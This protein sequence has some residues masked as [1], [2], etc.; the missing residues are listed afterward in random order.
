MLAAMSSS[1]TP[2]SAARRICARLSSPRR[3]LAPAQQHPE[4][5]TL[6]LGQRDTI[7]YVHRSLRVGGPDELTVE[8]N[9]W[10][11]PTRLHAQA[12]PVSGVHRRLCALTSAPAGRSRY[13]TV[14]RRHPAFGPPDD[15]HP[16]TRRSNSTPTGRA[17]KRR[18]PRPSRGPTRLAGSTPTGHNLCA[19]VL[20]ETLGVTQSLGWK[21]PMR[22]AQATAKAP[23]LCGAACTASSLT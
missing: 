15:S 13:A 21:V 10:R 7:A 17:T 12:G 20:V 19:E 6:A 11:P 22:C 3:M 9:V 14:L 16:R 1:L 8:S 23:D 5:V 18:G 2:E 4:L